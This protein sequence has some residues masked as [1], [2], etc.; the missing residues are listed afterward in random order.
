M[1]DE[2]T[3]GYI[4]I[5]LLFQVTKHLHKSMDVTN[6]QRLRTDLLDS[7]CT[8]M[9]LHCLGHPSTCIMH[10]SN[11]VDTFGGSEFTPPCGLTHLP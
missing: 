3:E 4:P 6:T 5:N 10:C 11:S 9:P 7:E 1:Q 8:L 2:A